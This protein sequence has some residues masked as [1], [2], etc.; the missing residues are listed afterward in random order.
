[1]FVV[2]ES[3]TILMCWFCSFWFGCSGGHLATIIL[4][5]C[6]KDR[7][8]HLNLPKFIWGVLTFS[9]FIVVEI[10]MWTR[11][12]RTRSVVIACRAGEKYR[13]FNGK[14]RCGNESGELH[15]LSDW[16]F[17]GIGKISK[18]TNSDHRV[19]Y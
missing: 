7:K 19:K 13:V 10:I 15:D 4:P 16:S 3:Y 14:P 18:S 2:L 5:V 9:W 6:R 17:A 12:L 1:M 8:G 11:V